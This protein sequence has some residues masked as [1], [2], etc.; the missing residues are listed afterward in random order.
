MLGLALNVIH[1][2]A[3]P[4]MFVGMFVMFLPFGLLVGLGKAIK[5][6]APV[7]DAI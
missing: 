3:R 2:L 5:L 6:I 7:K 1:R 4:L